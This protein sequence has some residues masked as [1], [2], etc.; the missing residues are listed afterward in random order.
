MLDNPAPMK[1]TS[2][3][4]KIKNGK[5][6]MPS[7]NEPINEF[8]LRLREIPSSVPTM[9]PTVSGINTPAKAV[10]ISTNTASKTRVKT[11]RPSMSVPK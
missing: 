9:V 2:A 11:S 5:A 10:P 3:I 6:F 8:T 1:A 7:I 4:T